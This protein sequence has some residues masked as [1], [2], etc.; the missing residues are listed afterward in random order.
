MFE[1]GCSQIRHAIS[2]SFSKT[3]FL[4][5]AVSIACCVATSASNAISVR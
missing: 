5:H 4:L 3:L 1:T 2:S